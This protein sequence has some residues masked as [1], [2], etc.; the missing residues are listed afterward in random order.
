MITK[1]FYSESSMNSYISE[2]SIE[3]KEVSFM[4]CIPG[5]R[6]QLSYWRCY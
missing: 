1:Y 5:G 4:G 2:H 3:R 6:F